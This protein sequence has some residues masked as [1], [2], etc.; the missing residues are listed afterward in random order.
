[1][2]RSAEFPIGTPI[3]ITEQIIKFCKGI[4]KSQKPGFVPVKTES[5]AKSQECFHNVKTK[6]EKD[7]GQIQFGWAI[8]EWQNSY[9]W[10]DFHA[11]WI[12]PEN[13]SI[14]ITPV[15]E[16]TENILFHPDSSREYDY[17][18]PYYKVP[19]RY[20]PISDDPLVHEIIATE[21]ELFY[22]EETHSPGPILEFER[23][24]GP[25]LERYLEL[26][27]KISSIK[28]QLML[29]SQPEPERG[30]PGRNDPCPCGSGLK[31]K[32]CCGKQ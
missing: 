31:F 8:W 21:Q 30:K 11:I 17:N 22:I 28:A 14:D 10:A 32:K 23:L 2:T 6:V 27:Q 25:V 16:G 24:E 26:Q 5:W 15:A 13:E 12:S 19:M 1:M 29:Q 7:E 4:D 18:A 20:C 3:R 9:I